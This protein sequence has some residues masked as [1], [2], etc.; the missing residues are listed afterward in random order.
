MWASASVIGTS[1]LAGRPASRLQNIPGV[2][3]SSQ[4]CDPLHRA[5]HRLRE[6]VVEGHLSFEVG[7]DR[8]DDERDA[9]FSS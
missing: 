3:A 5:A 4:L 1:A 8:L 6:V 2:S 9:A 7:E